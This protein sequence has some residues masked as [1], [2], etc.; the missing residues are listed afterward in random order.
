[1]AKYIIDAGA[2]LEIVGEINGGGTDCFH[3]LCNKGL[4]K[5]MTG[6]PKEYS[7]VDS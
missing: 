3:Y 4:K 1:M 5:Y 2:E 7:N 6:T